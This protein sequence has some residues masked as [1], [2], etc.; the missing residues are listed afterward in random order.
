M[1]KEIMSQRLVQCTQH[2]SNDLSNT[3]PYDCPVLRVQAGTASSRKKV[4]PLA[5][6]SGESMN[7]HSLNAHCK[8]DDVGLSCRA[9]VVES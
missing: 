4:E 7:M 6:R 8:P 2:N 5:H 9:F 3:T 1:Q